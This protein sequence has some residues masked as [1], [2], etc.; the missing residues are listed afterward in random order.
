MFTASPEEKDS[1]VKTI[2]DA[3]ERSHK[4]LLSTAFSGFESN[5]SDGS[6]IFQKMREEENTRKRSEKALEMLQSEV[7]YVES[8]NIIHENF[9]NPLIQAAHSNYPILPETDCTTLFATVQA[10][11][12]AHSSFLPKLKGRVDAWQSNALLGDIFLELVVDV[13][14]LYERYVVEYN[15]NLESIEKFMGTSIHFATFLVQKEKDKKLKLTELMGVPL[16]R[17]PKYYLDLEELVSF[18]A[19]SHPDS[20]KLKVVA[21]RFQEHLAKEASSKNLIRTASK[22]VMGG[23]PAG[24]RRTGSKSGSNPPSINLSPKQSRNSSIYLKKT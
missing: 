19:D 21:S 15:S 20:E 11:L 13:F 16:K 22:A 23:S 12:K 24:P 7:H 3:I 5:E 10:I 4:D 1:W 18:T 6:K 17:L 8:L 9:I 14:K 2:G